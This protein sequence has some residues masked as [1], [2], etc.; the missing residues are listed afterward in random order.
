M[1]HSSTR[2]DVPAACARCWLTVRPVLHSGAAAAWPACPQPLQPGCAAGPAGTPAH[3]SE[4]IRRAARQQYAAQRQR[5]VHQHWNTGAQSA[6]LACRPALVACQADCHPQEAKMQTGR[7]PTCPASS[8]ACCD[9]TASS[10]RMDATAWAR[11]ASADTALPLTFCSSADA[12]CV[13][14][15]AHRRDH[16]QQQACDMLLRH[17]CQGVG[18]PQVTATTNLQCDLKTGL[19]ACRADPA[20]GIPSVEGGQAFEPKVQTFTHMAA[21]PPTPAAS[22]AGAP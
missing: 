21:S 11:L 18:Q 19:P 14:R 5:Y 13:G 8:E 15:R 2:R 16:K 17:A 9:R 3:G 7:V 12:S 1:H 10:R 4:S 6:R 22:P 20:I